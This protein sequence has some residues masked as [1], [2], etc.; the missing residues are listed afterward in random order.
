M[1]SWGRK[2]RLK[3]RVAFLEASVSTLLERDQKRLER[4]EE[5]LNNLEQRLHTTQP[6]KQANIP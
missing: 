1:R 2:M 5:R 3:D 6:H 4:I